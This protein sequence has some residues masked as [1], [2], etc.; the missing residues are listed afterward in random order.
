MNIKKVTI[1]VLKYIWQLPQNLCGLFYLLINKNNRVSKVQNDLAKELGAS[2]HL[3]VA[4]GGVTLGRYIFIWKDETKLV[5][6]I[7]HECGHV[8]QSLIL[9]PLYL[10]VIG[11]PSILHASLNGAFKC[12]RK[13]G[14]YNY[15]HF[16][17]ENW[18]NKLMED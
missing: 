3:Q 4:R 13:D 11:I 17:T 1:E 15:F 7:K 6:V 8:K 12:C 18:A 5:E 9:G 14:K 10:L 2:V 16:Y